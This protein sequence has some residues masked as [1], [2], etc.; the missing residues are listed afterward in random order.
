MNQ[1]IIIADNL[2]Q[3]LAEALGN[4]EHD[5][6]FV[7]TDTTTREL[8]WPVIQD[9]AALKDASMITIPPTDEAKTLETL[10]DVWT[11]LQN[12]QNILKNA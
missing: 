10:A 3:S 8:C 6:L 2:E 9:Y 5:K 4:V 11:A 1:D 12:V 7:L